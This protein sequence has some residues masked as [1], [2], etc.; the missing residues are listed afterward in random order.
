MSN[1]LLII[2]ALVSTSG[3]VLLK[4]GSSAGAPISLDDGKLSFNLGLYAISGILLYGLS[5][6]LYT[7]MISKNDLGYIIPVS[8]ALVYIGIFLASFFIFKEAFT[9]MKVVGICLIL[10]GVILL[11]INK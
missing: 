4:I 3:L 5:F 7:Y 6:V 11:N 8:T 1:I 2:Y 10:G 9:A